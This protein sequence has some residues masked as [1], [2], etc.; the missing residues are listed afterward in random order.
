MGKDLK[1]KELGN[2]ITQRKDGRYMARFT[3]DGK[4]HTIYEFDLKTLKKKF[5]EMKHL[6]ETNSVTNLNNWTLDQFYDFWMK[7][8]SINVKDTTIVARTN[9]YKRIQEDL[10]HLKVAD[11]RQSHVQKAINN[12]YDKGYAY[13][14]ILSSKNLLKGLLQKAI[15]NDMILRNPCE[16]VILPIDYKEQIVPL[17]PEMEKKFFEAISGQ[18]YAELFY[19]LLYTGMRI[20]E[21]CALEWKDIDFEN[22][23]ISISK[24]LLRTKQ[25]DRK[26]QK[27]RK[28][29][30]Y[31]TFPK[32]YTSKR[33]IPL[34]DFVAYKFLKW[35]TK[36]DKDKTRNRQ[37]GSTNYLLEEYPELIFTT[38]TGKSLT[39]GEAWVYCLQGVNRVNEEEVF[40]AEMQHRDPELLVL[41]PH[42]FRHTYATR[43]V[44]YG[45]NPNAIQ[46]LLGHA[47]LDML[48]V[49]GHPSTEFLKEECKKYNFYYAKDRND[50]NEK[51]IPI[52]FRKN[53]V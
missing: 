26:N 43:C 47:T 49:Y 40:M 33:V 7:N 18:R 28:E 29:R 5:S 41:H 50:T 31:I 23:T 6:Y 52:D 15:E 39:P 22:K 4:T 30:T 16:G 45:L 21:A 44:E 19:I 9:N 10:G 11:I 37:W 51:V 42:I 3:V 32:S 2:G 27:L 8:Y 1:G 38:K 14:T 13:K 17:S 25:Y 36:Q 24:T 12:L 35:K 48:S 46:K 34:S 53:S 20:G